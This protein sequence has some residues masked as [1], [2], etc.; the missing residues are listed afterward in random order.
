MPEFVV[1]F[2]KSGKNT[3]SYF[4][5]SSAINLFTLKWVLL[6]FSKLPINLYASLFS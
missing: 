6:I 5:L 1:I 2:M 3:Q 4:F